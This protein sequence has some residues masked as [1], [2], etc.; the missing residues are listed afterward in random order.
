MTLLNGK[1]W[2]ASSRGLV[3][4]VSNWRSEGH[5]IKAPKNLVFFI[6]VHVSVNLNMFFLCSTYFLSF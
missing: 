6:S 4:K 2:P 1:A 5:E 3:V